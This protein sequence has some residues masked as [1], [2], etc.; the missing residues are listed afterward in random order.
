VSFDSS[1][2]DRI[3]AGVLTQLGSD[4]TSMREATGIQSSEDKV[5]D[6]AAAAVTLPDRIVTAGVLDGLGGGVAAVSVG[7][8][9]IVTPAAWDVAK[10]RG[11][12]I[13]R[14]SGSPSLDGRQAPTHSA[15]N[16]QPS[17]PHSLLIIVHH[18]DSLGRLWDDLRGTWRRE[19]LGCPDDAAKLAIAELARGGVLQVVIA[20]EQTHRAA[21]L[22]NRHER[23]KATA[24][25]DP[26]EV[27][28]IRQQIRANVWC[29]NPRDK[30]WFELRQLFKSLIP[31]P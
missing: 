9:A 27:K 20:A 22:A 10:E 23:V 31:S 29:L 1:T 14:H 2:I 16:S 11:L 30:S 12:Q 21:C 28:Q 5:Q 8:K 17:T 13:R 25:R 7:P 15:L 3:V 4:G 19:F 6:S 26:L 24:V 18:S